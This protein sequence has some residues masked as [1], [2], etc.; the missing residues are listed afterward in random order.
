MPPRPSRLRIRYSASISQ[1]A[2]LAAGF[3]GE[4]TRQALGTDADATRLTGDVRA[5]LPALGPHH[6]IALRAAGGKTAGDLSVG[7]FLMGGSARDAGL[8][9]FSTGLATLMRGFPSDTFA[10]SHAALVNAEYRVPLARPQRGVGTWPLFLRSI[11]AAVFVDAGHVWTTRFV[12]SDLKSSFGA[13]LSADTVLGFVLPITATVGAAWGHD[14]SGRV[15]DQT[16][17]YVR[18]GRAF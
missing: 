10:G 6:V 15:Q 1:E 3:T 4:F 12:A 2:G 13:E 5:Y 16:T 14:G 7:P 18:F 11:H 9:D 8:I 17:F